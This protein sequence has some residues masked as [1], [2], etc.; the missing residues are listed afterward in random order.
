MVAPPVCVLNLSATDCIQ[1]CC[2]CGYWVL[3]PISTSSV[4]PAPLLLP[5]PPPLLP[6]AAS[7]AV[8][9]VAPISASTE[10]LV[11]KPIA[12]LPWVGC[13]CGVA[14]GRQERVTGW[15]P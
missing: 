11:L 3:V 6:Q 15:L 13:R 14:A 7:A 8:S 2:S 4:L 12:V 5:L 9:A 10:R 1:A